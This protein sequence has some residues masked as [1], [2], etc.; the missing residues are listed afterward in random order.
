VHAAGLFVDVDLLDVEI[1]VGKRR[2]RFDGR[3]A[4]LDDEHAAD[5]HDEQTDDCEDDAR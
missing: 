1:G 2:D 3:A 4:A 5:D